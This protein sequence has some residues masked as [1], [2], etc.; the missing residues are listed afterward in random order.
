M[1]I[2]PQQQRNWSLFLFSIIAAGAVYGMYANWHNIN[3][4]KLTQE[5]LKKEGNGKQ[6]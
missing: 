2:T 4:Q 1:N 3:T 6:E 5:K